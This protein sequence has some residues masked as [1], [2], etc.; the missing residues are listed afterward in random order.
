MEFPE[1][2]VQVAGA[3]PAQKRHND[4]VRETIYLLTGKLGDTVLPLETTATLDDVIA[5][6]NELISLTRN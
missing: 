5:K 1:I 3:S 2:P 6:I 4:R